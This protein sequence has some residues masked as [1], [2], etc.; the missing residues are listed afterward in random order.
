MEVKDILHYYWNGHVPVNVFDIARKIGF[1]TAYSDFPNAHGIPGTFGKLERK[2]A[3]YPSLTFSR[4]ISPIRERFMLA[5]AIGLHYYAGD[6]P[7]SE[8]LHPAMFAS[9][10]KSRKN[11]HCQ[12]FALEL[13]L[14][15]EGVLWALK[16]YPTF[17]SAEMS[18]LFQASG[19]A[20]EKRIIQISKN[21]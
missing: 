5:F 10:T 6:R 4:G 19:S 9:E 7:I 18:R 21:I 16:K 12:N 13:L 20:C 2:S 14:P 3:N 8:F 1:D 11:K 17:T 15:T